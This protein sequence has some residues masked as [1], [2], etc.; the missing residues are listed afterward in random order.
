MPH[1]DSR[2]TA[3]SSVVVS[4]IDARGYASGC[5]NSCGVPLLAVIYGVIILL[6]FIGPC[7]QLNRIPADVSAAASAPPL[8]GGNGRRALTGGGS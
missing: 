6:V 3:A 2:L 8:R 5:W 4:T 7:R 1:R